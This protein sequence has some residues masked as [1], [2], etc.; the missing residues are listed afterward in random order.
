[1][2][3]P[4]RQSSSRSDWNQGFFVEAQETVV[5]SGEVVQLRVAQVCDLAVA[6]QAAE[7][8]DALGT[9]IHFG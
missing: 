3:P 4:I 6:G 9:I 8:A 5:L 1:M 7:L 2:F